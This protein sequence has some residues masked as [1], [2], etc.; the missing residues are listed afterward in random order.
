MKISHIIKITISQ[1][2]NQVSQHQ[3]LKDKYVASMSTNPISVHYVRNTQPII[4]IIYQAMNQ[5]LCNQ[6]L[7]G[8]F[9]TYII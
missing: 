1:I 7:N 3:T 8:K 5:V 6:T 9:I 2:I 4:I